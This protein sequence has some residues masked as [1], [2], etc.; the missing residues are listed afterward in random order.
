MRLNQYVLSASSLQEVTGSANSLNPP[1]ANQSN[2]A[3]LGV[4][5]A[6][7]QKLSVLLPH[8]TIYEGSHPI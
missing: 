1:H 5:I 4:K 6:P 7:E 8:R 3:Q 2:V